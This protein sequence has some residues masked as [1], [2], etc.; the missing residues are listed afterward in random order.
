M[1]KILI[2]GGSGDGKS[3]SLRNLPPEET[4]FI[5]ATSKMSIPVGKINKRY[6]P[7]T[8]GGKEGNLIT[9]FNPLATNPKTEEYES[10]MNK[11]FELAKT[12]KFKYIVIDDVQYILLSIESMFKGSGEYKDQRKIYS[13]IKQFTYTMFTTADLISEGC[14]VIFSWQKHNQKEQLVIPGEAFN[15]V[16]VPQGFFNIVLQAEKTITGEHVFRTN[17]LGLCKT[18]YGM[19]ADETIPNDIQSVLESINKYYQE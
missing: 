16:I 1:E 8:K 17:G 4:L 19:F 7:V 9:V 6:T 12:R 3:F 11:Y 13:L 18:P 5:R 15:E 10:K 14:T 2:T